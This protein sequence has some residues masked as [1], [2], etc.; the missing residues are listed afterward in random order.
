MSRSRALQE[1][2]GERQSAHADGSQN[3]EVGPV[4][5]AVEAEA[6]QHLVARHGVR[7]GDGVPDLG[8]QPKHR[9]VR[10]VVLCRI[11]KNVL[12]NC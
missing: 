12:Q 1:N 11:E 9:A 6:A 4:A 5:I 10:A 3:P 8:R 7:V 2:E